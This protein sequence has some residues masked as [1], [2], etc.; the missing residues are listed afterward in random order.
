MFVDSIID[1]YQNKEL[2]T[3][4]SAKLMLSSAESLW[5]RAHMIEWGL[6]QIRVHDKHNILKGFQI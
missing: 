1:D 5:D 3:L 6:R 2:C 4:Y